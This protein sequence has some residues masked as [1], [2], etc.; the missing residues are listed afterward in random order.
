MKCVDLDRA[1]RALVVVAVS[2]MA[3]GAAIIL[4]ACSPPADQPEV[5]AQA[6]DVSADLAAIEAL[7]ENVQQ[8]DMNGDIDGLLASYT[9]DIVSMPP[10]R[11]TI[12]GKAAL[13]S[14]YEEAY[15]QLSIEAL[16]M[17]PEET[18]VAGDWAFSR[19]KFEETVVPVGGEPFDV[20]GKFL[21]V[22]HREADGSWKI[23]RL[24]GNLDTP[25][26][27]M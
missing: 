3:L 16:A 18:H 8:A 2:S 13:R 12:V 7:L 6:P 9:D 11:P 17:T 4:S 1:F 15:A 21:F 19:G 5:A 10:D 26:S 22:Y 14:Y 24:I 25:S 27:G 20:I 23:A